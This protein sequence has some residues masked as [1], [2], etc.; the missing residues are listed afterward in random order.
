MRLGLP[1][2]TKDKALARAATALHVQ[3]LAA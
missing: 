1:L 3:A 2:A